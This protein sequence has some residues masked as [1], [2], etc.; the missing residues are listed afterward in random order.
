[1]VV[2]VTLNYSYIP[3]IYQFV[4]VLSLFVISV[5]CIKTHL[6]MLKLK[7]NVKITLGPFSKLMHGYLQYFHLKG[8]ETILWTYISSLDTCISKLTTITFV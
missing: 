4:Y 2:L 6:E 1:M 8:N 3:V 7:Q 5:P